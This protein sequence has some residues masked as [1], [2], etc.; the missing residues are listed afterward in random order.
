[1]QKVIVGC[2]KCDFDKIL[3]LYSKNKRI[4]QIY[5]WNCFKPSWQPT[6]FRRVVRYPSNRTRID[7]LGLLTTRTAN[8][9]TGQFR[10]IPGP[11][12]NTTLLREPNRIVDPPAARSAANT[13]RTKQPPSCKSVV[14]RMVYTCWTVVQGFALWVGIFLAHSRVDRCVIIW[15]FFVTSWVSF[16]CFVDFIITSFRFR[17][18]GLCWVFTMLGLIVQIFISGKG[19]VAAIGLNVWLAFNRYFGIVSQWKLPRLSS[20]TQWLLGSLR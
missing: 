16:R 11:V 8:L 7:A 12:A 2:W 1:M 4:I 17:H 9:E 19:M 13:T 5:R 15:S 14:L 20:E 18:E 6:H 3:L 10:P